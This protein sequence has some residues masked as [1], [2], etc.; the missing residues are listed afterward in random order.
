MV[1]ADFPE[2]QQDLLRIVERDNTERYIFRGQGREEWRLEPS[3]TRVIDRS[4]AAEDMVDQ[5][6]LAFLDAI[7]GRR[8]PNPPGLDDDQIWALGRHFGLK[9]PLLDWTRSPY[10]ALFFAFVET[11]PDTYKG[12]RTVFALNTVRLKEKNKELL[13]L[14]A[15]KEDLIE[16]V[17][18]ASHEN[19]RLLS[20]SGLFTRTMP[21]IDIESW[22]SE[23][24]PKNYGH[25]TLV[26]YLFPEGMRRF[27]LKHLN[28]MNI[29]Y[30]TLFPDMNGSALHVNLLLELPGY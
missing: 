9:T 18:A 10:V 25:S 8:G 14:G 28:W 12:R 20:Q 29:N 27:I 1:V 21:H 7:L 16:L 2:F 13:R 22:I 6:R 15:A 17:E 11:N 23:H 4:Y 30:L 3:L 24:F 5:H 26:R 19:A